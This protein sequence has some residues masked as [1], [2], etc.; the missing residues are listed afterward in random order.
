MKKLVTIPGLIVTTI[1]FSASRYV[2]PP[3]I[4]PK[5]TRQDPPPQSNYISL[6]KSNK[7]TASSDGGSS[8]TSSSQSSSRDVKVAQ[9]LIL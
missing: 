4:A 5:Y 7:F 8:L 6:K 1:S 9:H 2:C 3:P